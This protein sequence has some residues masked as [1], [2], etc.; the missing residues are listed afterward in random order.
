MEAHLRMLATLPVRTHTQQAATGAR[1]HKGVVDSHI[2]EER[3]RHI[4]RL[5]SQGVSERRMCVIVGISRTSIQK[6][7]RAIKRGK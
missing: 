2:V 3:R 4:R 7:I 5:L 1:A 6:H